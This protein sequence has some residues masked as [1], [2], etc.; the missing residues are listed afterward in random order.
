GIWPVSLAEIESNTTRGSAASAVCGVRAPSESRV[1][2]TSAVRM[3]PPA[4]SCCQ[5]HASRRGGGEPRCRDRR[6][7]AHEMDPRAR[8]LPVEGTMPIAESTT[9]I[10]DRGT[11]IGRAHAPAEVALAIAWS[12]AEPERIGEVLLA[13]GRADEPI[14]F[15]RA[16]PPGTRTLELLRQRPGCSERTGPTRAPGISR[17]QWSVRSTGRA[18]EMANVGRCE[19]RVNGAPVEAATVRPGD[20]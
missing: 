3:I 10:G 16:C 15:G 7:R 18:L 14:G 19:L 13:S 6:T 17:H 20:L 1:V 11:R 12:R 5:R 2:V 4:R 9:L 8:A